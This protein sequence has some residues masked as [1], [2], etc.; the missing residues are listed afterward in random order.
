MDSITNS[1]IQAIAVRC[2]SEFFNAGTPLSVGLAKEAQA[3]DLNA[4]QLRRSI[5]ATNTL[6]QLKNIQTSSD[7]AGEFKVAEYGEILKL[8]SF[9]S[10]LTPALAVVDTTDV[11]VLDSDMSKSASFDPG[12]E[13]PDSVQGRLAGL[14]KAASQNRRSL[15]D[16][17]AKYVVLND[18]IQKL[19]A[20]LVT[21]P[22]KDLSL[23]LSSA[24][25]QTGFSKVASFLGHEGQYVDYAQ[26]IGYQSDLVCKVQD[27][28]SMVK[29]AS[30]VSLHIEMTDKLDQKMCEVEDQLLK[31]AGLIGNISAAARK[32]AQK[33]IKPT[34]SK[35]A[36]AAK[37][38]SGVEN[39]AHGSARLL[40]RV[41]TAPIKAVGKAMGN[42]AKD[43]GLLAKTVVTNKATNAAAN[44][45]VGKKIGVKPVTEN[46][47]TAAKIS[48][49]K[50]RLA[51]AGTVVAAG[52]DAAAYDPPVGGNVWDSL[53]G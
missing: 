25:G 41:A 6:A 9:D 4:E 42:T 31:Q 7:R 27:L 37:K 2:V 14:R 19:A 30:E 21:Y 50:K 45:G 53:Q 12:V 22:E 52:I 47:A 39:A 34:I 43:A 26:D 44:T 35:A 40:T 38:V 28:M 13:V 18:G 17:E 48:S 23:A 36:P 10:A 51:A 11:P 16:A 5:E 32:A 29:Q 20:E 3:L 24:L 33:I 46:P 49:A 8:A 1:D 15:E